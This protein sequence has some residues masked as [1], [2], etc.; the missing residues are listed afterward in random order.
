MKK[1]L[2]GAVVAAGVLTGAAT[3]Q[4]FVIMGT[5]AQSCSTFNERYKADPDATEATWFAWAQGYMSG[6]NRSKSRAGFRNLAGVSLERQKRLLRAYCAD[7]REANYRDGI[8]DLF[9]GMPQISAE[10]K[11]P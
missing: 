3:A 9:S 10:M 8:S 5:G 7:H 1:S 6:L 2:A 4:P 11:A